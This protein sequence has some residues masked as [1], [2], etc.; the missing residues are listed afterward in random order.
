[1]LQILLQSGFFCKLFLGP[2]KLPGTCVIDEKL[3]AENKPDLS[4]IFH[5]RI[6][7]VSAGFVFSRFFH[8][9]GMVTINL[10]RGNDKYSVQMI[11]I[12]RIRESGRLVAVYGFKTGSSVEKTT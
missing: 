2:A 1:M 5:I 8:G 7:Y 9:A 12:H 10:K 4:V 3:F 11:Y 6:I